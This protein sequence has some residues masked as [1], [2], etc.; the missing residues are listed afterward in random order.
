MRNSIGARENILLRLFRALT[1]HSS[2]PVCRTCQS[3]PFLQAQFLSPLSDCRRTDPPVQANSLACFK[4]KS[5]PQITAHD[6]PRPPPFG[7]CFWPLFWAIPSHNHLK[8]MNTTEQLIPDPDFRCDIR[9]IEKPA[10][11][12]VTKDSSIKER[13]GCDSPQAGIRISLF[14][15]RNCVNKIIFLMI[16]LF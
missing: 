16:K 9:A 7:F 2:T 15:E 4:L 3:H 14:R 6:E 8:T 1:T 12:N 13:S 5:S 10:T 11:C